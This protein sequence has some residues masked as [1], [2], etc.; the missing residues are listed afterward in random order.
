MRSKRHKIYVE[1]PDIASLA[2]LVLLSNFYKSAELKQW[3]EFR[4]ELLNERTYPE[5]GLVCVYCGEEHLLKDPPE[6]CRRYPHNLA[7]VDHFIPVSKGGERYN[8]GNCVIAC[9]S[10]N[11]KKKDDMPGDNWVLGRQTE[12]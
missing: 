10:C 1:D 6:G 5:S 12:E 4:D 9:Y 3:L 2:S 11:Q 7:T 8:K